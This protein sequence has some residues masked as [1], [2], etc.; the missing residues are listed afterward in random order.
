MTIKLDTTTEV[1][2]IQTCDLKTHS[3]NF[4]KF[5]A[6]RLI[7]S[8]DVIDEKGDLNAMPRAKVLIDSENPLRSRRNQ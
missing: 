3:N 5:S 6:A 8:I 4:R 2:P 1:V 7:L